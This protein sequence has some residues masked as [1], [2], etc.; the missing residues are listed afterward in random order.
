MDPVRTPNV[1]TY[2]GHARFTGPK[3]LRIERTHGSGHDDI[4]ADRIVVA[5]GAS[6]AVPTVVAGSGVP[7]HTSESIMRLAALPERLMIL[8]GGY[9]GAE[10][11]HVFSARA[12]RSRWSPTGRSC[13]INRTS[14][15]PSPWRS[16]RWRSNAGT[17]MS[18]KDVAAVRADDVEV[19]LDLA[20]GTTVS[21]DTRPVAT[22]RRPD[23]DQ[24]D[25]DLGRHPHA[26]R[27]SYRRRRPAAHVGRWRLRPR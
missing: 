1:T 10:F 2:L 3:A 15:S 22:R 24:L 4:S 23:T 18:A 16:W 6:P 26:C 5:A 9:I 19:Y 27:R 7:F 17:S 14:P 8:G 21:G 20:D 13:S 25:L 12:A 11:A